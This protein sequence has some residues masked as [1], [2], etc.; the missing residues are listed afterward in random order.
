M[1]TVICDTFMRY[2]MQK[3]DIAT[4]QKPRPILFMLDEFPQLHF[5]FQAV[6]AALA[7]LRSKGVSLL[8]AQQSAGQIEERYGSYGFKQIMDMCRYTVIM[9]AK[10][11]GSA[12]Y[13]QEMIGTQ[14]ILT[15][16][17]SKSKNGI[18]KSVSESREPIY[19]LTDLQRLGDHVVIQYDGSYIE[20]EKTFYFK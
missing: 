15:V 10:D 13:F 1:T 20:A 14:K 16:S 12:R 17:V 5:N 3:D 4:G 18:S 11:P 8:L 9:S 7:T 6:S 2:F 19:Q